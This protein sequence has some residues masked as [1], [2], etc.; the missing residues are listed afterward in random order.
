MTFGD[1]FEE[2]DSS[3]FFPDDD[4]INDLDLY[5]QPAFAGN[6]NQARAF[7]VSGVG[8]VEHIFFQVET[9]GEF[10]F[11][12]RQRDEDVS[13]NQDYA[14]S[15]HVLGVGPLLLGDFDNDNDVDGADFLTWQR[16]PSVG[17]LSNWESEFGMTSA[18][19]TTKVVPEPTSLLLLLLGIPLS[20]GLRRIRPKRLLPVRFV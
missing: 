5:F 16:N 4:V 20:L 12:V 10:E 1:T 6:V 19:A 3:G 7:S 9:T 18:L 8:T 13:Q 11:W 14:V 15:W 17:S 2:Y